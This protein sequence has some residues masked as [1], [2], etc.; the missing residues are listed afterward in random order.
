MK[1]FVSIV[2]EHTLTAMRSLMTHAVFNNN[3]G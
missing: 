2:V 3:G 1:A